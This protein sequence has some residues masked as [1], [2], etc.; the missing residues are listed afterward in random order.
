MVRK[1]NKYNRR[2]FR[3]NRKRNYRKRKWALMTTP[4]ARRFPTKLRY[5]ETIS[6]NPDITGVASH[7]YSLNGIYDPNISGVGH[8]PRGFD[9]IMPMFDHYVV[10][11][12]RVTLEFAPVSSAVYP[13]IVGGNVND[14][15]SL[16]LLND[17]LESTK[18]KS[19]QLS[20]TSG[21]PT[22]IVMNVNPNRF[23]GRSHPL[24]DSQLKGSSASNP[25]EQAYLH[26]FTGPYQGV[27]AGAVYCNVRL[28]YS[29]IF[30]EPKDLAQS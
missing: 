16:L 14:D 23:L 15:T 1:Y 18:V 27:D 5:Q 13:Q 17:Y 26:I 11:G 21:Y 8:Q 19:R 24:S 10:V 3:K 20:N 7:V 30:I 9:Q 29:V 22:R 12:C 6:L 2:K 28:D 4:I 25:A